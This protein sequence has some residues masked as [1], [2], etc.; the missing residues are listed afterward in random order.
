M[1]DLIFNIYNILVVVLGSAA[2]WMCYKKYKKTLSRPLLNCLPGVF[3]SLGL[4]G[5]FISISYSLNG[6]GKDNTGESLD[7]TGKTLAEIQAAGGDNINIVQIIQDLIPAFTSSIVGL[8][9][10]LLVTLW[11]KWIFANEE[12]KEDETLKNKRPE[13]Y[14]Q[15]IALQSSDTNAKLVALIQLQRDQIEKNREYNDKLNN[16]ISN[17]STILKEFIDGFVNRMDG[18]FKQMQGAIQKQVH[19]FGEEQ[20]TKTSQLLSSITE[21]L[22]N[23]SADI[24]NNQRQSVENMMSNTNQELKNITT[25]VSTV[26][27][28]LSGEIQNSLSLLG[29][30]QANR[31]NNII[32]NYDAL[33]TRLSEQNSEFATKVTAQMQAE[34]EKVQNHNVESLQQMVDLKDA[35]QETTSNILNSTLEMNQQATKDV[36]EA[37]SGFVTDLQTSITDQCNS[38]S[39]AIISNV[40]SLNQA[41]HFIESLVAEIR[42]NYDQAVLSYGDAVN[43]AHRCNE[44]SEKVIA[45]TNNSLKNVEETNKSVAKVLDILVERQDNIEQLTKQVSHISA[46]IIELQKLEKTLNKI[47]S[48]K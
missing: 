19:N 41:Y 6:I 8:I 34:Y 4:L 26:L 31:L 30:E 44:S 10:A 29:T 35:Y 32:S 11:A 37:I 3:T 24:I 7:N 45:S 33:A 27:E 48:S 25:S 15:E 39:A 43:V 16:N 9:C 42:Q 2:T 20:F 28:Q 12:A 1:N 47:T 18:I 36:R 17:Q 40:E 14:I 13:E 23:V 46:T 5:T 38:L 21:R 22:S